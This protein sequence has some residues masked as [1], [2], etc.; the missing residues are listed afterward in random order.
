MHIAFNLKPSSFKTV[1]DA[2]NRGEDPEAAALQFIRAGSNLER[3]LRNRRARE[4]AL[5]RQGV[6]A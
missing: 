4:I 1:A 2:V 3:G 6:Y 5:Y